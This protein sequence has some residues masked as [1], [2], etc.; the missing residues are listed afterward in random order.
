[1]IFVDGG[2]EI[3]LNPKKKIV[4]SSLCRQSL[5]I[6]GVYIILVIC[7]VFKKELVLLW[8]VYL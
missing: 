6:L 8:V 3:F 7:L 2:T 4:W 5:Q 1:M